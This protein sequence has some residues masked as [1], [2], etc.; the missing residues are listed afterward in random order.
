MTCAT[1][2]FALVNVTDEAETVPSAV[3]DEVSEKVTLAVGRELRTTEN[4][5]VPPA[6]VVVKPDTGLTVMPGVSSSV[7]TAV[8]SAGL[9]PLYFGS[10]LV[11]AAVT[12]E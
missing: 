6:S 1:F 12:I 11:A 8:T 7:F 5:A 10:A 3:L 2:Q 4:V 9:R